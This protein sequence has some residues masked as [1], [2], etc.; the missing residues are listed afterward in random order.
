[1]LQVGGPGDGAQSGCGHSRRHGRVLAG[2]RVMM[3]INRPG[4]SWASKHG[5]LVPAAVRPAV[6]ATKVQPAGSILSGSVGLTR[7]ATSSLPTAAALA[8]RPLV[9]ARHCKG[10]SASRARLQEPNV[11]QGAAGRTH[12]VLNSR[13][14]TAAGQPNHSCDSHAA[15]IAAV[16]RGPDRWRQVQGSGSGSLTSHL[17]SFFAGLTFQ[18][19]HLS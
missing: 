8:R 3:Q 14:D 2:V 17:G 1:M 18:F 11:P 10:D 6:L 9:V 13:A 15:V 19:F 7:A 5:K 16:C 12:Q 4:R